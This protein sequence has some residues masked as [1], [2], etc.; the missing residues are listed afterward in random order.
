[1]KREW[2]AT[3]T[4]SLALQSNSYCLQHPTQVQATLKFFFLPWQHV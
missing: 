3:N 1:M 4:E 2:T